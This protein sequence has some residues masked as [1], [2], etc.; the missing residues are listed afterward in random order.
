MHFVC[1]ICLGSVSANE[2][3][4]HKRN[5]NM[6]FFPQRNEIGAYIKLHVG[7]NLKI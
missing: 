6:V 3:N 5:D 2:N 1:S 4:F 7:G